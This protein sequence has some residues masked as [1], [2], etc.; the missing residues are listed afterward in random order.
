[1][2]LYLV[3]H[4]SAGARRSGDDDLD[5]P[6]DEVG[7]AQAQAVADR[8]EN[9]DIDQLHSSPARRCIETLEPLA[10]RLA[11]EIASDH[12]LLEEQS[13]TPATTLVRRLAVDGA[14]A[15]CCTHGDLIPEILGQLARDGMAVVGMRRWEKG[16]IWELETRGG[17]IVS[18]RYRG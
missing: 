1:M 4:A 8:L 3:R 9:A 13:A 10:A 14:T 7:R 17:D 15:A 18:A 11:I 2:T 5:R 16:S 12:A 6:L